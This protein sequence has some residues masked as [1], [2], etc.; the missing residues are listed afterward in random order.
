[1]TQGANFWFNI[2]N[3]QATKNFHFKKFQ[4][5]IFQWKILHKKLGVI[6]AGENKFDKEMEI[7]VKEEL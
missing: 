4:C 5:Q 3:I 2:K 7:K 6:E 1:M